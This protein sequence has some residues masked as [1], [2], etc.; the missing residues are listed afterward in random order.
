MY[1]KNNKN[2]SNYVGVDFFEESNSAKE[3]SLKDVSDGIDEPINPN[4][5]VSKKIFVHI[6]GEVKVPGVYEVGEGARLMDVVN[7]AGGLSEW[8]DVSK[9]NLVCFI[10]DGQKINVPRI[11]DDS[12][13]EGDVIVDGNI[14]SGDGKNGKKVN[15]NTASQTEFECL[16]GIGPSL[17][18]KIISYRKENG[19]F[20]SVEELKNV[21]GIGEAKYSEIADSITV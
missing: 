12:V 2:D 19:K 4:D 18:A 14:R 7:V 3:D 10:E 16:S 15:I 1:E 9:I 11:G 20:K 17:A 5:K 8:A 13:S 21:S 6:I